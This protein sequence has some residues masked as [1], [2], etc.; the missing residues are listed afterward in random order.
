[1]ARLFEYQGKALLADHGVETPRGRVARSAAGARTAAE[2]LGG[3]VVVK[4]QAWVTDRR[5]VGGVAMANTPQ[6]AGAAAGRILG[7]PMGGFP[8]SAVLV[9][10]RLDVERELYAGVLIDD[11]AAAPVVV[12]SARGGTGIEDIAREHPELVARAPVDVRRGLQLHEAANLWRRV[13]FHGALQSEL[14]RAVTRLYAVARQVEARFA[15]V[16]PLVVTADGAVVAADCRITV[17]DSAVFRHPELGI[18]FPR[19]LGHPPSSLDRLAWDIEAGDYRGTFYFVQLAH[20]FGIGDRYVGFH[21]SGGGGSMMSMDA[22]ERRGFRPADYCDTSGNPPASKVYRAARI[23]LAQPDIVGYF[24]SGSGVANQEQFH[25]ARGLAKAFREVDLAVPAVI[26]LGGNQEEKAIEILQRFCAG[27]RAPVEAYGKACSADFCADRLGALVSH[28]ALPG[29]GV[30][31]R[32]S[33]GAAEP[34]AFRTVTSGTITFDHA[35]C[36]RCATQACVD[37]CIP[38]ILARDSAGRPILAI[39][40]EEAAA[41]ECIEC[42]ACEFACL[43]SGA[44]GATIDLPIAWPA[45]VDP[46]GGRPPRPQ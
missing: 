23:I 29:R 3:P 21:G 36:A 44:G 4:A 12:V 43:E 19:E 6:Q 11:A 5:A 34:Y 22:V 42:L 27:L 18:D 8:I 39:T 37:E 20:D 35:A 1:M 45:G 24:L 9:E 46:Y 32:S 40:R 26:R 14:A 31:T 17:D 13:G 7:Q 28:P 38:Q 10:E 15:E 30:P 25:S 2:D 41:G 16:N 33:A